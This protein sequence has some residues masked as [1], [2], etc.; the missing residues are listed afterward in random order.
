VAGSIQSTSHPTLMTDTFENGNLGRWQGR[1]G[2][3]GASV[4]L[5][6]TDAASGSACVK[7]TQ[8]RKG[9]HMQATIWDQRYPV[10]RFP[11]I[12]FD[13]KVPAE[14]RLVLNFLVNGNWHAVMLNDAGPGIIGGVPDFV[15]D[16]TWRHVQFDLKPIL[17][18]QVRQGQPVVEQIVVGDRDPLTTPEG[19]VARFDNF[20]IGQVGRYAPVLRWRATDTTGIAGFSYALDRDPATIPDEVSEGAQPAQTFE[21]LGPG[22]WFFHLRAQD[23]AGNW[24]PPTTY[25]LLHLQAE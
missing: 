10:D 7:L 3:N 23:G 4:E 11:I 14:T 24:G 19:A 5:D 17:Q 25:A 2:N 18:P 16:N 9:G 15:A 6:T 1:D 13:Y 8:Q 20:I 21:A 12:A 22:I